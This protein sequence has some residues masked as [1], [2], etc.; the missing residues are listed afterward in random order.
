MVVGSYVSNE[1]YSPM[2]TPHYQA[3]DPALAGAA[4]KFAADVGRLNAA[5]GL[6]LRP[7]DLFARDE[8]LVLV[9]MPRAFHPAGDTFGD[10][11]RFVG[12]TLRP[13]G[14]EPPLEVPLPTGRPL[15][16]VSFG[17]VVTMRPALMRTC[18][19]A[20]AGREWQVVM[21]V[22]DQAVPGGLPSNVTALRHVPQLEVLSKAAAFVTHGGTNSVV[23][24]MH[25]GVPMVVLPEAPEHAITAEQ[26]AG[27]GLGRRL[28]PA[29]ATAV[30]LYDAVTEVAASQPVRAALD[31][32]R[33]ED[34]RAGGAAAAVAALS[35]FAARPP[36]AV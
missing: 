13:P 10:R 9:P 24:A 34:S 12:A 14:V 36:V 16:L 20:F 2:R 15:V 11:F 6:R 35:E 8:D 21:A 26:V 29:T 17:T 28:D 18:L 23:E 1:H 33:E 25:F 30:E 31:R 22:D 7:R 5:Y 32:M 4:E 19:E 27:L 3:M